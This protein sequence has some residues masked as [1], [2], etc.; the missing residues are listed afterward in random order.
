MLNVD[1]KF[2]QKFGM[3]QPIRR[4]EDVRL[5][6]GKGAFTDDLTL[7]K[8]AQAY[9]LRSQWAHARIRSLDIT[10]ALAMPGVL[11]VYTGV[12]MARD[13]IT[14]LPSL[15]IQALQNVDGSKP[16]NHG[17]PILVQD[18]VRYVGDC[19]A[20]V[21]AETL[22]QARDAA[23][24]IELDVEEL[25][26]A[27][28]LADAMAETAPQIR[29]DAPGNISFDWQ[30]GDEYAVN[31]AFAR[32]DHVTKISLH[33]NRLA[34]STLE[35]RAALGE[36]NVEENRYVLRT[37]TQGMDRVREMVTPSLGVERD[38]VRIITPDIGGSFGLKEFTYPEQILVLYAAK[39]LGRPVKWAADRSE[40]FI[41]DLHGR[42]MYSHAELAMDSDN[43]ILALRVKNHAN[44]GAYLSM[45]GPGIQ[46][47]GGARI[48]GGLYDIPAM[49]IRV[50]GYFTNAAPVDAYRGAG[51]PEAAYV[52]ERLIDKA[53]RERGVGPDDI[54]RVNFVQ[55]QALPYKTQFG[56]VFD[57]GEF[58]ANMEK[59]KQNADWGGFATRQAESRAR[60]KL[61]G[62]GMSVYVESTLGHGWEA[63]EI[64][65]PDDG[66]VELIA[67]TVDSGQ[68]HRT[69]WAQ[70]VTEQLG[71]AYDDVY[72]LQGDT[73]VVEIG[74]GTA[75]SHSTYMAAGAF[76][77]CAE[78]VIAK[79]EAIAADLLNTA[80]ENV[81]FDEG[82]FRD[83]ASNGTIG[84][85]EVAAAARERDAD[86]LNSKAKF[87]FQKQTFPNGCHICELEIDP[88]TGVVEIMRYTVV[89]DFGRLMNPM[90]VDGQVHGGISQGLGQALMEESVHD[91]ETGQLL[92]GSFM[93]Y[94]MP[95]A[96]NFSDFDLSYNEVLCK[97]TPYGIKG[98]GESGTTGACPAIMNAVV[99]ALVPAGVHEM[100]MP[101]TPLKIWNALQ[102]AK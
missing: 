11:A 93:D 6:T 15:S 84:I 82:L 102:A 4:A 76:E 36:W 95:R 78:Q 40:S 77:M 25:P 18:V 72:L 80:P 7:P 50:K 73:D 44:M 98:C 54:R 60:G 1:Q 12:E 49:Y 21:V 86:G 38:D 28:N 30:N 56:F 13:N 42:D 31:D 55:P 90:I 47:L 96:D 74:E 99:N 101:A 81:S 39:K 45:F 19:I 57:S 14:D 70:M 53:A 32:A 69:V 26:C 64:N 66:S 35:T 92:T 24:K 88:D 97:T 91:S 23:E 48:T 85:M 65:F 8:Q 100:D 29:G 22:N 67:G 83:N 63:A 87:T 41:S 71:V 16:V 61:R 89:D 46:T 37:A 51:R 59:A 43:R 27:A 10:A 79:G 3:G 5:V 34:P 33:H 94:A 52:I 75:G 17:R 2:G 20:F 9:V 62:I 68:G 58:E